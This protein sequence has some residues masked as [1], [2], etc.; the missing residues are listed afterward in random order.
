[1]P[2]RTRTRTVRRHRRRPDRGGRADG[3]IE[4]VPHPGHVHFGLRTRKA[5]R[6]HGRYVR[7]RWRARRPSPPPPP[8]VGGAWPLAQGRGLPR[9]TCML[10]ALAYGSVAPI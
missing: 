8:A 7:G 10:A 3:W 4:L 9:D 2:W 5:K 1:M 6:A